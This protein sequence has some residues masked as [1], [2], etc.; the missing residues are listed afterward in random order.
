MLRKNMTIEKMQ[1]KNIEYILG[2]P[3]HAPGELFLKIRCKV[4]M[5]QIK[6]TETLSE[7]SNII[8]S[9]LLKKD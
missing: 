2:S 4:Q 8:D 7:H 9:T 6:T 5:E 3:G 1:T